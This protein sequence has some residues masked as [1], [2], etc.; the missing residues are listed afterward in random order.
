[1]PKPLILDYFDFDDIK[2]EKYMNNKKETF[3]FKCKYCPKEIRAAIDETSNWV[4][5][6]KTVH[7]EKFSKDSKEDTR[8]FWLKYEKE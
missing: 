2:H 5:H 3:S 1:M 6:I 8:L 4:S 7:I